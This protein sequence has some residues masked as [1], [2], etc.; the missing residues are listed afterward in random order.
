MLDGQAVCPH[1]GKPQRQPRQVHCRYC[2]S[3]GSRGLEVCPNCGEPLRQDWLRPILIAS[4]A[5]VFLGSA[6]FGGSWLVERLASFRPA[7]AV[8]TVQALVSD[9][10]G[11]VEVP[12]LTPS[13]TPS[14]TPTPT[15]TP[16]TTPT[17]TQTPLPTLTYTPTPTPTNTPTATPTDTPLPTPTRV[18]PSATPTPPPPTPTPLPTVVPPVLLLPEDG[19]PYDGEKAIIKLSWQS[20]HTLESDECYLV[21]VRWT[22]GGA[23]AATAVCVQQ[24]QW[25]ADASLYLR[26]DQETDRVYYWSVRVVQGQLDDDGQATYTPL[27]PASEERSFFWR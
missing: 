2:G 18:R 24:T 12:T 23:P 3:V 17:P 1:C 21:S 5:V 22:E 27:S 8:G 20:R 14:T 16:T 25:F 13:L 10:P 15:P 11:F 6:Y 4:I 7:A 19:A 26:A 9:V